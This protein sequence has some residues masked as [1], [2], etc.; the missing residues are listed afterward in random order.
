M[1]LNV[2]IEAPAIT[3]S[4]GMLALYDDAADV[5]MRFARGLAERSKDDLSDVRM[6][7]GEAAQQQGDD[8]ALRMLGHLLLE[9]ADGLASA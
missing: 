4:D 2:E 3:V 7:L 6:F 1:K 9:A 8:I 5:L